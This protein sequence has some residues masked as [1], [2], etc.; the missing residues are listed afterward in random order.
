[1]TGATGLVGQYLIKDLLLA[2]QRLALV[3]RPSKR[4]DVDQRVELILQRWENE[5]GCL[6]PRPV[7]LQ[8]DVA[9]P[10][11]GLNPKDLA[12]VRSHCDRVIHNAAI[13]QFDGATMDVEPW[14]T[15]L[16][17]TRH[18][19]GLLETM[20]VREFHYVSTAYVCG[21]RPDLVME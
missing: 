17:G 14:R 16:G 11:L 20:K 3:V 19:L 21:T 12:W 6:L 15:N 10:S 7:V 8:G 1:M 4:L 13:L 2:G 18:V 9:E 5:L